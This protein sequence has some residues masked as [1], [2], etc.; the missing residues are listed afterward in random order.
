MAGA[1]YGSKSVY[2]D[3]SAYEQV[4][5]EELLDHLGVDYRRTSGSRG[6]QFQIRECPACG[7]SDWKVYLGEDSGYGNC[8]H[9]SCEEKYNRW[10]FAS[11]Q[12]GDPEPKEVGAMFEEIA[13]NSGWKPKAKPQ[14]V[15]VPAFQ[16]SLKLPMNI[17]L[18][19]ANGSVGVYLE[20]RGVTPQLARDFDLRNGLGRYDYVDEDG[21]AKSI[22]FADRILFPIYDTNGQLVTFQ[23]RDTTDTSDR[24]YL[25]PAR[26]P[27]TAR[28]IYNAH[29][30]KAEGWSHGVLGEGTMDVIALQKAIDE[31]RFW[32]GMGAIGSFGKSL[33][34]DID[35]GNPTQLQAL[36]ELKAS[37][38]QVLTVVWDGEW[39]ALKSAVKAAGILVKHGFQVRI[40][41][42]PKDKDPADVPGDTIRFVV[43]NAIPYSRRL[44]AKL[45]LR[46]PYRLKHV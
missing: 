44:E 13:K 18:P 36:L 43:E 37:G 3:D 27:S 33:T 17:P 19:L 20:G 38:M 7:K 6:R 25:F 2:G 1:G 4:S 35:P 22:S 15:V 12:M 16:G 8:F 31:N 28:F 40:G 10:T 24:K 30:A 26:L 5:T 11:K 42:M 41:V 39:V 23:G 29:R 34:L 21:V 9:G 46:D 32:R 14:R 45:R